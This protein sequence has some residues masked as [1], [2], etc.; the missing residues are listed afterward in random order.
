[1]DERPAPLLSAWDLL[2]AAALAG[3]WL[4]QD[5]WLPLLPERIPSHWN[6]AG[7]ING[8][9]GKQ[10]FFPFAIYPGLGLWTLLFLIG[11]GI[12][13]DPRPR[14]Q[15]GAQALLALRGLFPAGFMLMAGGFAPMAAF[16]GGKAIAWG[17]GL[18][19]LCL[20]LG[21]VPVFRL[22]RLAPP[23]EGATQEDYRFGGLIYWNAADGRLMVPKRLGLGWTF[24]F[25]RP[26]AWVLLAL[27]LAPIAAV[28]VVLARR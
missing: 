1:M 12:R 10:A 20:I 2:P 6:A 27:M 7:V 14:G 5:H 15:I 9:M 25:A 28:L 8:W 4:W 3:V 26:A 19:V 24:N 17:V 16:Y 21:L 11:A 13:L 23:I 18:L 22:A